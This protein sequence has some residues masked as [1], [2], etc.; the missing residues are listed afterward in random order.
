MKPL[1]EA[2]IV[3]ENVRAGPDPT[4]SGIPIFDA[5]GKPRKQADILIDIGREHDLFRSLTGTSYARATVNGHIEVLPLDGSAYRELLAGRYFKLVGRGCGRNAISDALATLSSIAR[6]SESRAVWTRIGE[7]ESGIVIDMGSDDWSCVEV[8]ADGWRHC[9]APPAIRRAGAP[10]A[11]PKLNATPN[12]GLLWKYVN[13]PEEERVLVA[14][15]MLAALR[16]R[17]PYPQLHLSGEQGTGKSVI[18]RLLRSLIDPTASPHRAPP[19]EVRDL[20]VAAH[21]SWVLSLDNVSVVTPALSDALCRLATG[22]AIAERQLYTNVDE[23]LVELQRPVILN[24]IEELAS[25][26]DLAERAIHI[27][28]DPIERRRS[29]ADLLDEFNADAGS[30]FAALLVALARALREIGR[31]QLETLPR[32]ADFAKWAAAGLPALGFTSSEFLRAYERNLSDGMALGLESSPVGVAVVS[33]ARE[34]GEWQGTAAELLIA[35]SQKVGEQV[36]RGKAWPL[37][38]RALSGTLRR[39]APALRGKGIGIRFWKTPDRLRAHMITLSCV[40][41]AGCSERTEHAEPSERT[42]RTEHLQAEE[43]EEE[44]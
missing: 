18:A 9:T 39:I 27:H 8:T 5:D 28:L 25:R 42:E 2:V 26:P 16:P 21:N 34:H 11:F 13:V 37:S 6:E 41:P 40:A 10:T 17:G 44:L 19:R 23:V 35:L 24:G 38:A 43:H 20:L 1:T 7:S 3:A 15:F 31:V 32:M 29:E 4:E 36:V 12:F 14:A 33:L 22:G 30:I